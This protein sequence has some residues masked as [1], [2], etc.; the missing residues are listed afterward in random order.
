[1]PKI[2]IAGERRKEVGDA[3]VRIMVRAGVDG[4]SLRNLADETG[5]SIGAIRHY[6]ESHD[7]LVVFAMRE[8]GRRIR[9]RV[10]SRFD[11]L[12][13][14]GLSS[15]V[16]VAE[17]LAGLLPLGRTRE[18]DMAV[19]LDFVGASRT[20]PTLHV[21]AAEHHERTR[22]LITRILEQAIACGGLPAELDLGI[23]C[24][25]LSALLDGLTMQAVLHPQ[26]IT[27]DLLVDVLRRNVHSLTNA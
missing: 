8:L 17:L 20:K 12:P 13:A 21:V 4:A 27:P 9:R 14:D 25:R 3:V 5:L 6:F 15:A 24:L 23:E 11:R 10:A 18:E 1:M 16:P 22:R 2:V 19:W 26:H 7:E